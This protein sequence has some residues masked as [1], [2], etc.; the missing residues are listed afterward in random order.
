MLALFNLFANKAEHSVIKHSELCS[1]MSYSLLQ[2]GKIQDFS[3]KSI[4][5]IFTENLISQGADISSFEN[6]IEK[7]KKSHSVNVFTSEQ[8]GFLNIDLGK[9]RT[10]LVNLQKDFLNK[11]ET[12]FPDPAG[13]IL[14]KST[15]EFT[16]KGE[17]LATIRA[18]VEV[19]GMLKKNLSSV[20]TFTHEPLI[21]R[22]MEVIENV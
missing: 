2:S 19:I 6:K 18:E 22:T 7:V 9:L 8:S 13:I 20:F 15:G 10:F 17:I 21:E 4:Y 16:K 1:K 11:E 5:Q 14:K 3:D 12:R